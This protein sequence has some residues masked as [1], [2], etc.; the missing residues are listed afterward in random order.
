M[1]DRKKPGVAF[2]VTVV[3]VVVLY[4]LSFGPITGYMN[5]Q[6]DWSKLAVQAYWPLGWLATTG[7]G[8]IRKPLAWYLWLFAE[9]RETPGVPVGPDEWSWIID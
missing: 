2:W 8:V 4:P 5:R 6:Q 3:V 9:G 1:T 7:P